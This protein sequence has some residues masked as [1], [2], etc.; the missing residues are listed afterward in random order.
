MI[1][2]NFENFRGWILEKVKNLVIFVRGRKFQRLEFGGN[3]K[4][5]M[6]RITDWMIEIEIF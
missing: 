6:L 2:K 5:A 4:F 3:W 1:V